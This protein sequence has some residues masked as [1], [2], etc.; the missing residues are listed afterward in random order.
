M[1]QACQPGPYQ[2]KLARFERPP[3]GFRSRQSSVGL[4][5]GGFRYTN[6]EKL[7]LRHDLSRCGGKVHDQSTGG[8]F[9]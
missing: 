1:A 8:V 6:D 3:Q 9:R 5:L 2:K 7:T 4:D